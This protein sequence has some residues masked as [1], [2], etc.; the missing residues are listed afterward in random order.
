M[1]VNNPVRLAYTVGRVPTA[2]TSDIP[3]VTKVVG[4][5][6]NSYL[7][8]LGQT[9]DRK[10]IDAKVV[11]KQRQAVRLEGRLGSQDRQDH[12]ARGDRQRAAQI[13]RARP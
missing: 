12:G 4:S 13:P 1:Y 6:V 7:A 8:Y 11:L 10:P 3:V 5:K 9:F 2:P